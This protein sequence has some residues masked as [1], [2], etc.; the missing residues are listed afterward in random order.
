MLIWYRPKYLQCFGSAIKRRLICFSTTQ[1]KSIFQF[2]TL[3]TQSVIH[4][5]LHYVAV[6]YAWIAVP[7][8]LPQSATLLARG[9]AH[10]SGTSP[11]HTAPVPAP[12]HQILLNCIFKYKRSDIS[13]NSKC[14]AVQES[15][16]VHFIEQQM[17]K[18]ASWAFLFVPTCRFGA[19]L[20][21]WQV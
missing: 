19:W 20:I 12:L 3:S 13:N 7:E 21:Q 15:L 11:S 2:F 14:E 9:V 1:N 10:G 6:N 4:T 16:R 17:L 18:S 8:T 5:E